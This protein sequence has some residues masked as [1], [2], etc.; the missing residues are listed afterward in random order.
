MFSDITEETFSALTNAS[1]EFD[2][3]LELE[4]GIDNIW[5]Y[6]LGHS[7]N[8]T[9]QIGFNQQRVLLRDTKKKYAEGK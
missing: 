5:N 8:F 6:E 7:R 9:Y 2:I 1:F 3:D 4:Q